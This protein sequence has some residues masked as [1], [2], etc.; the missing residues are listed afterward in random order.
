MGKILQSGASI[1]D[2]SRNPAGGIRIVALDAIT[3]ALQI[4]SRRQRPTDF[5]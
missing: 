3:N 2:G 1:I 5:H 4:L